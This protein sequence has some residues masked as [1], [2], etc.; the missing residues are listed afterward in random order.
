M[1]PFLLLISLIISII[2]VVFLIAKLKFNAALAL[3]LGSLLM[4]I[5][6]KMNLLQVVNGINSGFG[7]MMAGIGFPIGFGIILGQLLSDAG[8]ANVIADKIVKIFPESK[9]VYAIA[10]AGFI[11]SIPVFFDVTFVVLIPVAMATMKKVNKSIP[12]MIGAIS[13]GAGI[14]HSMIPPTPNPLAAAEIFG[15]DLGIILFAGLIIGMLALFITLFIYIKILDRGLWNKEKDENNLGI[16][17]QEQERLTRY[18]SFLEALIPVILPIITILLNTIYSVIFPEGNSVFLKFIGT[19][20]ISM[21]L[22]TLAAYI[23][24]VKYI[25]S[26]KAADSATKSLEAAGIV[27]LITGA[28]GSFAEIIKL[29][30]VNDAIVGLITGL[31]GNVILVIVLSWVLGVIFRQITGSGTVAGITSMTMMASVASSIAIHPVFISLACLSGGMFGATINDSGFWIVSNMSGFN[32]SGGVKT[33]T[34]GEA[35]ASVVCLIII[36]IYALVAS[37]F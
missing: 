36:V 26:K 20:S 33:Y 10:F 37:I 19:K 24:A 16:A 17:I 30:G 8:G 12:Y 5:L 32:F 1:S 21:L 14:A 35:L 6:T 34:L 11:L 23:I 31:G 3:V 22:G 28:G 4:G 29:S 25:G 15:F 13:I 9:A 2:I 7:G 18:P 27:F